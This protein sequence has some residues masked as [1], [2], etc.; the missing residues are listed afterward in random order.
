MLPILSFD[1]C[2]ILVLLSDS[3]CVPPCWF[4]LMLFVE[5]SSAARTYVVTHNNFISVFLDSLIWVPQLFFC[6]SA[7]LMPPCLV[8]ALIFI[9]VLVVWLIFCN[10]SY[11]FINK[12]MST[13]FW[14]SV[15]L[16]CY[17]SLSFTIVKLVR[18]VASDATALT[19]LFRASA[20]CSSSTWG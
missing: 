10:A 6:Y 4:F 19:R 12:S 5:V 13:L 18:L 1:W 3:H 17:T 7:I 9:W 14:I 11:I 15:I 8:S 2:P 16:N 20:I